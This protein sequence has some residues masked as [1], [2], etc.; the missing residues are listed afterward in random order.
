MGRYINV[1][2]NGWKT[3]SLRDDPIAGEDDSLTTRLRGCIEMRLTRENNRC[4][5]EIRVEEL[6]HHSQYVVLGFVARNHGEDDEYH[7]GDFLSIRE[8]R[9]NGEGLGI[10]AK[11]HAYAQEVRQEYN[12]SFFPNSEQKPS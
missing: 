9:F 10:M 12:Q 2:P 11:A 7:L 5:A 4:R 1:E 3:D 6:L 8:R